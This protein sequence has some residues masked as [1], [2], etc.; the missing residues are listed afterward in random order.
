MTQAA[1]PSQRTRLSAAEALRLLDERRNGA[2]VQHPAA[3][4]SKGN[5]SD[6]TETVV[7]ELK[8]LVLSVLK[9][10]ESEF[11]ATTSL[12][13]YGLDSIAATELGGLF[14]ARFGI[15]VPPTVFFEFPNVQGFGQYLVENH[16][17]QLKEH[18]GAAAPASPSEP[19]SPPRLG[20]E[21]KPMEAPAA[22]PSVAFSPKASASSAAR[23]ESSGGKESPKPHPTIA[24]GDS[25]GLLTIE[26]LWARGEQGARRPEGP[27]SN[28]IKQPSRAELQMM[29]TAADR[30][31][32]ITMRRKGRRDLECAVYGEGPPV[33]MLGGL[34]MHYAAMW[35]PQLAPLGAH[36]RLIM[37]HM[38]GCGGVELYDGLSLD[39]LVEDVEHVLEG[40]G[41]HEPL[42]VVGCSFGG[43]L[44]Q[45]FCLAHPER[46][47][48]LALGVTTPISEGATDF[49]KL[50]R[51][52]QS[53][54]SFMEV[55]RGWPMGSL[56]A[57]SSVIEGF[58]LRSRLTEIA[59][60]TLVVAGGKDDYTPAAFSRMIAE[61]V[62]SAELFEISDAGHLL[63]F[64][65]YEEFNAQLLA[66]LGSLKTSGAGTNAVASQTATAYLPATAETLETA[67]TYV[68][69]GMQGHC[70]ILPAVAAQ[71]AF[72]LN[73]ICTGGKPEATAYRSYFVTSAEEAL[74]AALRLARHHARNK[75]PKSAG[76]VLM[77]D[78][79]RR[80]ADYFNPLGATPDAALLPGVEIVSSMEEALARLDTEAREDFAA[81]VLVADMGL[82]PA[83]VDA[84]LKRVA[85]VSA[86][87]VL[88]ESEAKNAGASA[89]LVPRIEVQPDIV[90]FGESISG[91]QAPI[92]ACALKTSVSN[93]WLMTP[94]EGYARQPMAA[95]GLPLTL[96]FKHLLAEVNDEAIRNQV[97]KIAATPHAVYEAHLKYGNV[98][99]ARVARMHGYHGRF[100]EARG[101][102]SKLSYE[103]EAPREIIDCLLNVGTAPRGLNPP[104]VVDKVLETH[105]TEKDYWGE[106]GALLRDKTG[107]D[108]VL[109]ASSQTGALES[110][111]TLGLMAAGGRKKMLCF[112]GGAGFSTIA[113]ASAHDP[114]YDLFRRPFQPIYPHVVYIDPVA[115]DAEE[116]LRRELQSGEI[117]LVW[118]ET[119]QVEG[120]AIRPLPANLIQAVN[121]HRETGGYLVAVDETQ[122]NLWTGTFLH[123]ETLVPS[124]DIVAIGTS[125]CDSLFPVGA[126]LT[127]KAILDKAQ[128]HNPR[129]TES[130]L[131]RAAFPLTAHLALNALRALYDGGKVAEARESGRYF[132]A[133][134]QELADSFPLLREVR[135]EGLLLAIEFDLSGQ[136]EFVQRSFGYLLWGTMLRDRAGGV[137]V[138][139]CP[140]HNNAMRIVPA[141]NVSREEIDLIVANLRR[142]LQSGVAGV[143]A[144]CAA[145]NESLGEMRTAEFLRTQINNEN[146]K[147]DGMEAI[148]SAAQASGL[149]P[150]R[151]REG[152]PSVC[153]I[154][155]GVG[156]ISMAGALKKKGIPFDCFDKRERIGGIWAFDDKLQNTSVWF[157]L[158]M[159]T[160]RGWYQ[161]S[162]FPMPEDYPDFPQWHQVQAYLESYVDHF[163][164]R[165]SFHLGQE[166]VDAKRLESGRWRVVLGSG[167]IRHYDALVV[168]NGHHNAPNYPAY[169]DSIN[170]NGPAIHS[171]HYRYRHDYRGK[172]VMIVGIGNS[173]AQIAVDVSFD[174]KITYI[175]LRRGVYLLP[176]YMFGVRV[177]KILGPSLSWWFKKMLPGSLY[178]AF[179]T[180]VYH[181]VGNHRQI[182]MP[183]PD[184]LMMTCLPTVTESLANRIGDGKIKLVPEVKTIEGNTVELSDGSAIEVDAIIYSTGYH[185]TLPFFEKDFFQVRDNKIPLFKRVFRPGTPNLAFVGMFQAIRWGFLDVMEN[186]AKLIADY[187]AGNY[188]LPSEEYMEEDISQERKRVAR[189]FMHTLR[190][191]YYLHGD[192]YLRELRQELKRGRRR[193]AEG[194]LD[195]AP[196]PCGSDVI[197]TAG[198]NGPRLVTAAE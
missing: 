162:D 21:P 133:H 19:I 76:T 151:G 97:E 195:P 124:P 56:P 165:E 130:L 77:V 61:Q 25:E 15:T 64:T 110:G 100:H 135:G 164:M 172:R 4:V 51:E 38:P 150:L 65:H 20:V 74:D 149:A 1:Q 161:Y 22:A 116:T 92:G 62:P 155:A 132:K 27:A 171:Q 198:A 192:A 88:V 9:L 189:E 184:H 136:N 68:Q 87:S 5:A 128:V 148:N 107:F 42:P 112:S 40:L 7:A 33:L 83:K 163:D 105:D 166:V 44:A 144:D 96:A 94:N 152:V 63:P 101:M 196:F 145:Y 153:I 106:L 170:F 67:K 81:V 41:I 157:G 167:E 78:G 59:I 60:P 79:G 85:R 50:M 137:A 120:N 147:E 121:A 141:L 13:E 43:V 190:N 86:L 6:L 119:F 108:V 139:V 115:E 55:N 17:E 179:F 185:T 69:E 197:S 31:D 111:I 93:P 12:L 159:N 80:W 95:M 123:S 28:A 75:D 194:S 91:F 49:Q 66:F 46:C 146:P 58:D 71:T 158:N 154:G 102:R 177:D 30:A 142:R 24:T 98:G 126:V 109:P 72:L 16:A 188:A 32:V 8:G 117:G 169:A 34:L 174:A 52:L 104:D 156:G 129:R 54:S 103:G 45:A 48:G 173:G 35:R 10:P 99:Y 23:A 90:V 183:K 114:L 182:G 193:V 187:F 11:S 181:L 134:L 82:S 84:F 26:Q 37:F 113:A 180:L 178:P 143:I 118:M 127:R 191:N 160:P 47:S 53:S 29:M 175:S 140:I 89:R 168:A 186:Q 3:A 125:I 36:Y 138:V 2:A 122:T 131:K 73:H 57:Y 39:S 176:H 14:T 70:V 18:Y